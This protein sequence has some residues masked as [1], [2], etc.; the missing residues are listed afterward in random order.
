MASSGYL[1]GK[2]YFRERSSPLLFTILLAVASPSVY[3]QPWG[4]HMLDISAI[5]GLSASQNDVAN[6]LP[7]LPHPNPWDA[8]SEVSSISAPLGNH[9][10][11]IR[12]ISP[13]SPVDYEYALTRFV[14]S[15]QRRT[16]G[17]R[18]SVFSRILLRADRLDE[19]IA[20]RRKVAHLSKVYISNGR[21]STLCL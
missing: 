2:Q 1:I 15:Q 13:I 16:Y 6:S 17:V 7:C 3:K 10:H 8:T 12:Q 14:R 18:G 4:V 9:H 20:A 21:T 19:C 11:I 5:A